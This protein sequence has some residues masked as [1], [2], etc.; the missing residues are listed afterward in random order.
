MELRNESIPS[1]FESVGDGT[2][3]VAVRYDGDEHTYQDLREDARAFA[4][5]VSNA[6]HQR[7]DP[8][9]VWLPNRPEWLH[10]F[11]GC[12][13]LGSPVVS[14]NT[15]Y[16]TNELEHILRD[17]EATTLVMQSS[18]LTREYLSMLEDVFPS[19][20]A[21]PPGELAD[22]PDTSLERVV[23]LDEDDASLPAAA[24]RYEDVLEDAGGDVSYESVTAED[25]SAVFYT[26]GTTSEPKGVVHDHRN[27]V[28]HGRVMADWLGVDEGDEA[29]GVMPLCGNGGFDFAMSALFAGATLVL[30]SHFDGEAAARAIQNHEVTYLL[31]IGEMYGAMMDTDYDLTSLE[32]G[33]VYLTDRSQMAAIESRCSFPV[34]QPYGLTEA[35]SHIC[36]DPPGA[37]RADRYSPGGPTIHE[38]IEVQ[39]RD[40]E[41]GGVLAAGEV[42]EIYVRGYSRMRE[43]LHN[44]E[45]TAEAI[46]EDGW[47]ATGDAG[48]IDEDGDLLYHSRLD[49]MLRLRGFQVRPQEIER[50]IEDH[51]DVERAQVVGTTD[52][53]GTS[54][55]VAFVRLA[56]RAEL[57]A[58][59]MRDFLNE[60]VADYKVPAAFEWVDSYPTT[61]S[62]NG[63]KIQRSKLAERA[64]QL[65]D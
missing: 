32:R 34:A 41:T 2:D 47:L 25:P 60:N 55:A 35:R 58:A 61:K 37:P 48:E 62:P 16:R 64:G 50:A 63:E 56:E 7:G 42:G 26:S 20:D 23:V 14:V 9:A 49:D 12:S 13:T 28:N 8:V 18:F 33:A 21:V 57:S 27:V 19:V 36:I 30:Q 1:A 40:P 4:S 31:A 51:H 44:P 38:D 43:Y 39:V 15:R 11:F 59:E 54:V 22:V 29:L 52:A 17:S 53:D 46:D 45:R 65:L 10:A 5:A 24:R 6:G 3:Q